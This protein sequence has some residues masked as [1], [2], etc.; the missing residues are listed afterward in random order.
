MSPDH[1]QHHLTPC[2]KFGDMTDTVVA[3]QRHIDHVRQIFSASSSRLPSAPTSPRLRRDRSTS[4][5]ERRIEELENHKRDLTNTLYTV[6]DEALHAVRAR[7][8]IMK[9]YR[10]LIRFSARL[11]QVSGM[12]YRWFVYFLNGHHLSHISEDDRGFPGRRLRR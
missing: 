1:D 11:L 4:R 7:E 12:S 3:L 9:R 10:L 2:E 5:L 8:D 6:Q